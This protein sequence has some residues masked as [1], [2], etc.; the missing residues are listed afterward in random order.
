MNI[1]IILKEVRSEALQ[2]II[3]T[4]NSTI[5]RIQKE[6]IKYQQGNTEIV[7]CKHIIQSIA[8]DWAFNGRKKVIKKLLK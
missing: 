3:K 2:E 7:G 8:L 1:Q 4:L 6:E 5:E